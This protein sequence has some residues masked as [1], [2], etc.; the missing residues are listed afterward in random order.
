MCDPNPWW[1]DDHRDDGL[2]PQGIASGSP[3]E[4]AAPSRAEA[5]EQL[6]QDR[7]EWARAEAART[8]WHR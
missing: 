7:L 3:E 1:R 5:A 8:G 2:G 4:D 6:R